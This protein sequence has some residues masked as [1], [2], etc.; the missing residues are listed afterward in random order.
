MKLRNYKHTKTYFET[1]PKR[2]ILN[3]NENFVFRY[4]NF[5]CPKL[6]RVWSSF[7]HY[8][9]GARAP[10]LNSGWQLSL[11]LPEKPTD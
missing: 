1:S 2:V 9:G 11:C 5:T 8:G 7:L 10:F 3:L 6:S 4:T